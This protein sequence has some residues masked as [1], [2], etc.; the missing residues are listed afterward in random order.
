MRWVTCRGLYRSQLKYCLENYKAFVLQVLKACGKTAYSN[1][2]NRNCMQC[3]EDGASWDGWD[4]VNSSPLPKGVEL[5]PSAGSG[6]WQSTRAS[7]RRRRQDCSCQWQQAQT[8]R[9]ILP[10]VQPC[11]IFH[12]HKA[13]R[14]GLVKSCTFGTSVVSYKTTQWARW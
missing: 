2:C 10:Q 8:Y 1:N 4:R 9:K 3:W 5:R 11:E 7:T 6:R 12:V 13:F 14:L